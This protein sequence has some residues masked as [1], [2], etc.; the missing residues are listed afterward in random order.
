ML[1]KRFLIYGIKNG[2]YSSGKGPVSFCCSKQLS[3]YLTIVERRLPPYVE[4]LVTHTRLS[5]YGGVINHPTAPVEVRK[6]FRTAGLS[7]ALNVMRVA[8][9]GETQ[10]RSMPNNTA[11]MISF[12]ACFALTLSA[13]ATDGSALAPSVR[14]LI[15]EAAGVLERIGTITKHRNGLSVLYGRYLRQI[16]KKSAT[17]INNKEAVRKVPGRENSSQ[18]MS[19]MAIRTPLTN[20]ATPQYQGTTPTAQMG[21]QA[22]LWPETLQFSSMS[23]DQIM[24]VLNQPANEFT[25][26]FGGL[27][28]EDMN[29]FDWLHWPEFGM[30]QNF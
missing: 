3:Q 18:S 19:P 22:M 7:S 25:P 4:I 11:I 17:N 29:N 12:A 6:F 20:T 10:L 5:A 13:Y 27:S 9:Q 21:T 30:Q 8:I 24:Q 28:W 15:V 2:A 1:S 26:S 23:N 14:K 16:V